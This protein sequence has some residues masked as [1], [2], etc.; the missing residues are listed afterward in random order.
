LERAPTDVY[1]DHC[2][3]QELAYQVDVQGRPVFPPRVGDDLQWR[4]SA[5]QGTVYAAT[6]VHPRGESDPYNIVLVDLDEGFRMMGTVVG[7]GPVVIGARV[8]VAWRDGDP[9]V[10]VFALEGAAS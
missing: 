3:R 2:R 1:W 10:P 9:P 4:V 8:E 6:V 7:D 5:G